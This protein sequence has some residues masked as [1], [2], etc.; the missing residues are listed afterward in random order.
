MRIGSSDSS[1]PLHSA[2]RFGSPLLLMSTNVYNP[3]FAP[4]PPP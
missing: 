1:T 3:V 2:G 4:S